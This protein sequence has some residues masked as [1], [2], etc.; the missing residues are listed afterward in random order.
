MATVKTAIGCV[1]R[2][3]KHAGIT[4]LTPE[5][6]YRG[7][8]N[9]EMLEKSD[10]SALFYSLHDLLIA[11]YYY[12][13][14]LADPSAQLQALAAEYRSRDKVRPTARDFLL[15]MENALIKMGFAFS[16]TRTHVH[17]ADLCRAVADFDGHT[18]ALAICYVVL[19]SRLLHVALFTSI[20]VSGIHLCAESVTKEG[21]VSNKGT[22]KLSDSR[23]GAKGAAPIQK[24]LSLNQRP[25]SRTRTLPQTQGSLSIEESVPELVSK[26]HEDLE[27][28][29][30]Y[31]RKIN[32]LLP[33]WSCSV[34]E[35]LHPA[36][37]ADIMDGKALPKESDRSKIALYSRKQANSQECLQRIAHANAIIDIIASLVYRGLSD[38]K[39][40]VAAPGGGTTPY[41]QRELYVD[42]VHLVNLQ[43][44][45]QVLGAA[46]LSTSTPL[47]GGEKMLLPFVR[48]GERYHDNLRPFLQHHSEKHRKAMNAS[49]RTYNDICKIINDLM[50]DADNVCLR[51]LRDFAKPDPE[52]D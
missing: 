29:R 18:M 24:A 12:R 26:I 35:A 8:A 9:S 15:V 16:I 32:I 38:K 5:T 36:E 13:G 49:T 21:V 43:V 51:R 48:G 17:T 47:H 52:R 27:R 3:M 50:I 33:R 23:G 45:K 19:I 20:N 10:V 34:S 30:N 4:S 6:L 46:Y 25:Q 14:Q 7:I 22:H 42:D 39:Y 1:V 40:W 37:I 44:L 41:R 2:A 28:I 11:V 31:T